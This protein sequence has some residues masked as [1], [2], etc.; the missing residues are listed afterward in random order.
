MFVEV[1]RLTYHSPITRLRV[2]CGTHS[3]EYRLIRVH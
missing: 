3:D 1:S 2:T